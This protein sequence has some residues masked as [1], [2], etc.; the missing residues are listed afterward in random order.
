MKLQQRRKA[1]ES[2]ALEANP[3]IPVFEHE[4]TTTKPPLHQTTQVEGLVSAHDPS[5]RLFR[6]SGV[7]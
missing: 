6:A 3:W 1:R 4:D 2:I 7:P 5:A